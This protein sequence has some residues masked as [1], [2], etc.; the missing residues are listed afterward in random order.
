MNRRQLLQGLFGLLGAAVVKP[1]CFSK[2]KLIPLKNISASVVIP[3]EDIHNIVEIQKNLSKF[4]FNGMLIG[5]G[6][7]FKTNV[8]RP[9]TVAEVK[10]LHSKEWT[11]L[12]IDNIIYIGEIDGLG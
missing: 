2:P 11:K 1:L 5:E 4:Y 12:D 9:I 3:V 10:H 8:I 6:K 7:D